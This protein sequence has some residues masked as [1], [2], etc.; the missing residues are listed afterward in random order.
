V[1]TSPNGVEGSEKGGREKREEERGQRDSN[2]EWKKDRRVLDRVSG[3]QEDARVE[4][5][6]I[7]RGGP[8]QGWFAGI[9]ESAGWQ[10]PVPGAY[11]AELAGGACAA[12]LLWNEGSFPIVEPR[13]RRAGPTSRTAYPPPCAFSRRDLSL[14]FRSFL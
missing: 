2:R 6:V 12:R 7:G 14:S 10:S 5:Y 4:G 8:W 9:D 3:W 13:S 1:D 11:I